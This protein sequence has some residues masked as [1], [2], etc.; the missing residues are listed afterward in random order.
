MDI[1][2]SV[3]DGHPS[4]LHPLLCPQ[5][6]E[7]FGT[8]SAGSPRR[9]GFVGQGTKQHPAWGGSSASGL[10]VI[11]LFGCLFVSPQVLIQ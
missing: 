4:S 5:S 2:I 9:A 7:A 3:I 1:V 6:R 11:R 10:E 8:R